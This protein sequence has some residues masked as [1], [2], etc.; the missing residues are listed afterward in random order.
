MKLIDA[1][2]HLGLPRFLAAEELVRVMDDHRVESAVVCASERCP[3]IDELSR[4]AEAWP[5]RFRAVGMPLGREAQ[6]IHDAVTAQMESGFLGIRMPATLVVQQPELLDIIGQSGG[7]PYMLG[8]DLFADAALVL[9]EFL[10]RYP[11]CSIVAPHFGGVA[12]VSIF[13]ELPHARRLLNHPRFLVVF[14]RQGAFNPTD[15]GP[16]ASFFVREIGWERLL[17]ASEF[18]VCLWRDESY[19]WTADWITN[20]LRPNEAQRKAIFQDNAKRSLFAPRPTAPRRIDP[21]WSQMSLKT[22]APVW[23]FPRSSIN[24]D[25]EVHRT[26]LLA[27]LARGGDKYARYSEFVSGLLAA[28]ARQL[29]G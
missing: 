26:I 12:N 28:A 29:E 23:L 2:A 16:V 8:P 18:P 25:E 9:A 19:Q 1:Y 5:D 27:Y 22:E 11:E 20:V 7:V 15:V 13:D 17:W 4:A 3:D 21:K 14:S 6:E 24:V 10:D